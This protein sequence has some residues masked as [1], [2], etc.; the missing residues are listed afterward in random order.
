MI[1]KR[2]FARRHPAWRGGD[3]NIQLRIGYSRAS[4]VSGATTSERPALGG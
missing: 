3:L 2:H 1:I 4:R